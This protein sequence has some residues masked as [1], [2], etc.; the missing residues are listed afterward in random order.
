MASLN[1]AHAEPEISGDP[2]PTSLN[3]T[4][5][6]GAVPGS[7]GARGVTDAAFATS[8]PDP[9][10]LAPGPRGN[11]CIDRFGPGPAG[12]V[13][14]ECDNLIGEWGPIWSQAAL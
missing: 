14:G 12:E 1:K 10:P 11:P 8:P 4:S 13:C 6:T 2:P 5:P 7:P 3:K 9:W